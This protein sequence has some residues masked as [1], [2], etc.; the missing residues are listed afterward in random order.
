MLRVLTEADGRGPD[1]RGS[2]SSG[3]IA[4]LIRVP[5]CLAMVA[6]IGVAAWSF[7]FDLR[8]A[9]AAGGDHSE[10]AIRCGT[11][12]CI[13][14]DRQGPSKGEVFVFVVLCFVVEN[15]P[16]VCNTVKVRKL[17]RGRTGGGRGIAIEIAHSPFGCI[18]SAHSGQQ[19]YT[20]DSDISIRRYCWKQS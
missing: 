10:T 15:H 16:D 17:I 11:P 2:L 3:G 13:W 4:R 14:I 1:V 12:P 18:G 5:L 20:L 7:A 8:T 19:R 6:E 9:R